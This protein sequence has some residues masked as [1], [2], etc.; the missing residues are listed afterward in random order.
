MIL[1]F[2]YFTSLQDSRCENRLRRFNGGSRRQQRVSKESSS[3]K[4]RNLRCGLYSQTPLPF[5]RAMAGCIAIGSLATAL[6]WFV[7]FTLNEPIT[8]SYNCVIEKGF[9]WRGK[10]VFSHTHIDILTQ[11]EWNIERD[12]APPLKQ[13]KISADITKPLFLSPSPS[14]WLYCATILCPTYHPT[15][16][17]LLLSNILYKID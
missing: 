2:N 4:R 16:L 8:C 1:Y 6:D 3:L 9:S 15:F 7:S 11:Y 13:I 17:L 5:W 12:L 10:K 14:T